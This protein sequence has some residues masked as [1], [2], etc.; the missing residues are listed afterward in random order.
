MDEAKKKLFGLFRSR[1]NSE[2]PSG[3]RKDK[4]RDRDRDRDRERKHR[5]DHRRPRRPRSPIQEGT[6]PTT[7]PE[8]SH[9]AHYSRSEPR[10]SSG[11]YATPPPPAQTQILRPQTVPPAFPAPQQQQ[12]IQ[13]PRLTE[14][15]PRGYGRDASLSQGKAMEFI[16]TGIPVFK[17]HRRGIP[18][19]GEEYVQFYATC[20]GN[21][22]AGSDGAEPAYEAFDAASLRL[23][24]EGKAKYPWDTLEQP[25][26]AF[27]YGAMP[28]TITLNHW[29]GQ[30]GNPSPGIEMRDPGVQPRDVEL[31]TI[32]ERLI[33][34]EGGFEEDYPDLMYKNLYKNLLRDPDRI[35]APHKAMEKQIAD[36][37]VV[38]SRR[39]WVD[40]SKQENQ[41]V[42]KFFANAVYTD[43]GRY[44][45]FFHQLLLSMELDIRI[46][47]KQ[48]TDAAKE[49]LLAQLP[50]CIAWDLALAR[51]W[52]ECMKIEKYKTGDDSNS[53]R[54]KSES[55]KAQVKALRKFARAMK[56]PN[57]VKVDEILKERDPDDK[58]LEDRSSDAMSYFTG[59]ILPGVTLPWLIMNSLIDCDTDAGAN[60]LA[61]LT[62][63]HPHSGFQ[64]KSTTYWSS[65]SIVGKV[66]APTCREIGGWIGPARPAPD[67]SRIQIARIRQRRPKQILSA[68][69]VDSMTER[70]DP[71]GPPSHS[72]PVSEYQLLLPDREPSDFID[73]VRIEKLAL[74]PVSVSSAPENE[75]YKDTGRPLTYDAAVQFAIDG[76]SWPLRLSYD[77][78]FIA[79]CPCAG[80]GPHPLF[81][82]YVYQAVKVDQILTIKDWGGLNS[83]NS[84]STRGNSPSATSEGREREAEEEDSEKVLVVECFGVED[85]E[86]L[87]RA[88]CSHWGLSAVVADVER[89]CMSCAVREA[90]AGCVNV[91]VLIEGREGSES[92]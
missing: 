58:P 30:S 45:K 81:F 41:V 38:L 47:S 85:N 4:E 69:D 26:M 88:W 68:D 92:R 44:K 51:K 71:L 18:H 78:S 32:L 84:L 23:Q 70:S 3:S 82:D 10:R 19:L 86:V 6:P 22:H 75:Q 89:T 15:P 49:R 1:S 56:W 21:G 66:L 24:G 40:F 63:M 59:V 33:Y 46:H 60:S 64:Y 28:G 27:C 42:A 48:H 79:A 5:R 72:Y 55:K 77:V 87:A 43:G 76:R 2:S 25:S 50:P 35:I 65:T 7:R 53:I 9:S 61:A 67:L 83:G 91:V 13:F 90:Y 34:L 36:L 11:A 57:L 20:E 37:I 12:Q 31:S 74:K 73:T 54:L 8:R 39:E 29:V 52:R 14:W 62:H 17:G 80:A 16:C